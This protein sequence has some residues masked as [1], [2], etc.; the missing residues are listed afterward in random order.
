MEQEQ[1]TREEELKKQKE[2]EKSFEE[3]ERL[4]RPESLGEMNKRVE[5]VQNDYA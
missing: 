5:S 1:L 4:Y 3:Y 2:L